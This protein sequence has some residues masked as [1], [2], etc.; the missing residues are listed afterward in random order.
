MARVSIVLPPSLAEMIGSEANF[1]EILPEDKTEDSGTVADLLAR[2][3]AR[4]YRFR[5]LVF[6]VQTRRLTGETLVFLNGRI[7][8]QERGLQTALQ[9]GDTLTLVPFV[10]GG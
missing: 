6:D 9:D 8:D 5:Q 7:L 3:A 2:L 10:E 1:A 4:H